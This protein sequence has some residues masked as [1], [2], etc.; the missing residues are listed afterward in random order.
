MDIEEEDWLQ[1]S[2]SELSCLVSGAE[3][4]CKAMIFHLAYAVDLWMSHG[5]GRHE[6]GLD[7]LHRF[8]YT[9]FRIE[10]ICVLSALESIRGCSPLCIKIVSSMARV[11]EQ[12]RRQTPVIL[13]AWKQGQ[14]GSWTAQSSAWFYFLARGQRGSSSSTA[15]GGPGAVVGGAYFMQAGDKLVVSAGGAGQQRR[16]RRWDPFQPTVSGGDASYI[17]SVPAA[18]VP[19]ASKVLM[20]AA[21]GGSA[22]KNWRGGGAVLEGSADPTG[23]IVETAM[24]HSD[25]IVAGMSYADVAE[26][27][28]Q[29]MPGGSSCHEGWTHGG[30]GYVGGRQ[31]AS[32][33]QN[34]GIVGGGGGSCFIDSSFKN[35][36]RKCSSMDDC[37][38]RIFSCDAL[39][40]DVAL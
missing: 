39:P 3:E 34:S 11:G 8:D 20:V 16:M 17:V 36:V 2:P 35:V 33:F 24:V 30:A 40:R 7:I 26:S 38:I 23:G 22:S 27:L 14:T 31:V 19:K 37:E 15:D 18:T 21:G 4:N 25:K 10:E 12:L 32:W 29:P 6:C 28:G 9:S 5:K 13:R 1:V